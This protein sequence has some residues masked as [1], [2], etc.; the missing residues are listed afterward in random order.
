MKMLQGMTTHYVDY[1]QTVNSFEKNF[2]VKVLQMVRK[3]Q[4]STTTDI[5]SR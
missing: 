5:S 2:V 3:K 4:L 1:I